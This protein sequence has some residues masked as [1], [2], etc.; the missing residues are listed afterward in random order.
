METVLCFILIYLKR[1][2]FIFPFPLNTHFLLI[3]GPLS[4]I[5]VTHPCF[6]QL[7]T[8]LLWSKWSIAQS[9]VLCKTYCMMTT[10]TANRLSGNCWWASTNRESPKIIRAQKGCNTMET[11][12]GVLGEYRTLVEPY[13]NVFF[14][15]GCM[16]EFTF[17]DLAKL[18]MQTVWKSWMLVWI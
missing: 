6:V 4:C 2:T 18:S 16:N 10:S 11:A 5:C 12:Q 8:C 7:C 17:F 9:H 1:L 14:P 13:A 15:P 3:Y